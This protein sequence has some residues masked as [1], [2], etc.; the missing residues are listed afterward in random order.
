MKQFL[1]ALL[2]VVGSLFAWE[3]TCNAPTN[4]SYCWLPVLD[5]GIKIES[6]TYSETMIGV[7]LQGD[8]RQ[9]RIYSE[10]AAVSEYVDGWQ[11]LSLPAHRNMFVALQ[12]AKDQQLNVSLR[13]YWKQISGINY[14]RVME[15]KLHPL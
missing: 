12:N 13:G 3:G 2:L 7:K 6:L 9:Y 1:S 15:I 10:K 4:N 14:L 5:Y 11:R 8:S